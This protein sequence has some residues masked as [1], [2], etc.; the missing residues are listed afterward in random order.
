[1]NMK[2][3]EWQIENLRELPDIFLKRVHSVR[4]NGQ[5]HRVRKLGRT[6]QI[7]VAGWIAALDKAN[8]KCVD[9]GTE[10]FL[11][12]G[13]IHDLCEGGLNTDDNI[14][15]MCRDCNSQKEIRRKRSKRN[16]EKFLEFL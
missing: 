16:P 8:W 1:M 4:V 10:K 14:C 6:E 15:P 12:I 3:G 7:T 2:N 11:C 5:N 13:H 9:C